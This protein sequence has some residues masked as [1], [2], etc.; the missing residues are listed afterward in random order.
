MES[1]FGKYLWLGVA[2][3]LLLSLSEREGLA[4]ANFFSST[5]G[6]NARSTGSAGACPACPGFG[7]QALV[8]QEQSFS[9]VG[10]VPSSGAGCND[11]KNFSR[12]GSGSITDNMFGKISGADPGPDGIL[13]TGDDIPTTICGRQF[14]STG[15]GSLDGLNCGIERFDPGSQGQTLPTGANSVGT[16]LNNPVNVIG[17]PGTK[18]NPNNPSDL[19]TAQT[20]PIDCVKNVQSGALLDP[21]VCFSLGFSDDFIF[22]PSASPVTSPGVTPGGR[23]AG[24]NTCAAPVAAAARI[25]YSFTLLQEN[26]GA[27]GDEQTIANF[28]RTSNPSDPTFPPCKDS[29][30]T[31]CPLIPGFPTSGSAELNTLTGSFAVQADGNGNMTSSPTVSWRQRIDQGIFVMDGAGQFVHN[32]DATYVASFPQSTYPTG[33]TQTNAS[34]TLSF[35]SDL[36]NTTEGSCMPG[37]PAAFA[38]DV[39]CPAPASP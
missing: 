29:V 2:A 35:P 5:Q 15:L 3:V 11:V 21:S 20:A 24:S 16:L 26:E 22:N 31:N 17:A 27:V 28:P 1:I 12:S 8:E 37:D 10:C 19:V 36:R 4:Q 23:Q 9:N 14:G 18:A 32:G 30:L 39:S 34:Q 25:C 6:T 7:P 33:R 13:G 38:G